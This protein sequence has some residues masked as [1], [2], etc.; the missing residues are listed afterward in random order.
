M[1]RR[2]SPMARARAWFCFTAARRANV[3]WAARAVFLMPQSFGGGNARRSASTRSRAPR[4]GVLHYPAAHDDRSRC[5]GH[6]GRRPPHGGRF[7][8]RPDRWC[9]RWCL[10]RD[11]VPGSE[12]EGPVGTHRCR[13]ELRRRSRLGCG[14]GGCEPEESVQYLVLE[15]LLV[16]RPRV[17]SAVPVD[18]PVIEPV[19]GE[20][21]GFHGRCGDLARPDVKNGLG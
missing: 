16:R 14:R 9:C 12:V 21:D 17:G 5:S 6:H 3:C 10:V 8:R 2:R 7:R 15:W 13:D 11:H 4:D 20:A 19:G 1:L 18:V